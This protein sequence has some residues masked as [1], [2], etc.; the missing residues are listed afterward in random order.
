MR[1][2]FYLYAASFLAIGASAQTEPYPRPVEDRVEE[3]TLI[4]VGRLREAQGPT[5][6]QQSCRIEVDQ[7]LFGAI[8]TNKTL[9][10]SYSGT[11]RFYSGFVGALKDKNFLCFVTSDGV[12][13]KSDSKYL[14]RAV[15]RSRYAH[16]AFELATEKEV[17]FVKYLIEKRR[18]GKSH[19]ITQRMY[20]TRGLGFCFMPRIIG[21]AP[22]T[23]IV[24]LRHV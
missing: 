1:A 14:T 23:P 3:A 13:Q 24:K 9:M 12:E 10:V 6:H 17:W 2:V 5:K 16:D 4:V 11:A 20:W 21:S 19:R 15:G 22:L 18:R 7:V 8:P